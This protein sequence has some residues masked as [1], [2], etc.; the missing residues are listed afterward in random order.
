L[1]E[2]PWRRAVEAALRAGDDAR[3]RA[4][5]RTGWGEAWTLRGSGVDAFVKTASGEHAAMLGAEADG[6]RALASTR[7]VRVPQVLAA[8]V[9]G[10]TTFLALERLALRGR[11]GGAALGRALAALHRVAPPCGPAGKRY[12]WSRDNWIGGTPQRN[13]WRDDWCAFLREQRLGPQLAL[14]AKNAHR[15]ALQ[16][17]GERLLAALPSLLR[18]HS[19]APSLL[20]G[21]LWS[22]NAATLSDG[23][24]VVFDPAVYVGDREADLAM[25]ELFGGFDREF[26]AAYRDAWPLDAG[27]E[28]RRNLCN[29]YHVL[30]HL[31]LFGGG[32]LGQARGMIAALLAEAAR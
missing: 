16:R 20:H 5:G 27:Y 1:T 29:L 28:L 15:G 4:E 32:Y 23:A 21:D 10:T 22:G 9:E 3:W 13:A 30:N 7:T 25:T 6:L 17:D 8:G 24:P 14:A 12:G 11:G 19:P 18:G 31:N 2:P 26:Y